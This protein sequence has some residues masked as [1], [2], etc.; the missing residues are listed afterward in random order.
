MHDDREVGQFAR[1][2]WSDDGPPPSRWEPLDATGGRMVE[3]A[4]SAE[5]VLVY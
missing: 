4:V 1:G 2:S 5:S 3:S